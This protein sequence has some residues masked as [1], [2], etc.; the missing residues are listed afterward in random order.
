MKNYQ[1]HWALIFFLI[2]FSACKNEER[3][4][5]EFQISGNVHGF[6]NGI[7]HLER[8]EPEKS[9]PVSDVQLDSKGN[10]AVIAKGEKNVLFQ[11]RSDDGRRMMFWP[12]FD[13]IEV[14]ADAD[15]MEAFLVKGSPKTQQLR[16][17]NLNQYRLYIDFMGAE[18]KLDGLDREKDT[19][20]WHELEAVTDKALIAYRGYLRNYCDTTSQPVLRAHAA[21]SLTI[22]G[23]YH[24]MSKIAA[25]IDKEKPGSAYASFIRNAMAKETEGRIAEVAPPMSGNDLNGRPFDLQQFRGRAVLLIFWASYCEFSRIENEKIAAM[26]DL[27][28]QH[29]V[30]LLYFSIDDSEQAWR[31]YLKTANLDWATHLR[32]TAGSGSQEIKNWRVK[33]IPSNCLIDLH[34]VIQDL[35]IRADELAADLPELARKWG[36]K[37]AGGK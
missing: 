34:G 25:R 26:A 33:A 24:Y 37:N 3:Q 35:D 30:A 31:D 19:T 11:L 2:T 9:V 10:F 13:A 21:L 16:D 28:A 23:N 14:E 8:I 36:S 18:T 22:N 1:L 29:D 15:E 27:F 17:L 20:A 4:A 5:D 12:E 6:P 32:G 7:L